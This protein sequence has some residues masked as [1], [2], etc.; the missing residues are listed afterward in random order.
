MNTQTELTQTDDADIAALGAE[1]R[2]L[3]EDVRVGDDLRFVKGKWQK[4]VGDKKIEI[5]ATTTFVVD[6]LS[7]KRG[8]ICWRD[9][10]PV[11]KLF[12]RP[13]DGFVSPVRDRLGELDQRRWPKNSKGEPQDP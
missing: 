13:V 10:K 5:S 2:N 8:W 1:A 12:G 9:R 4:A 7:Y 3:S 6:M 11:F